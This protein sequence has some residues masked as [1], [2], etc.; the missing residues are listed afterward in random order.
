[1][2]RTNK[3][4]AKESMPWQV[5]DLTEDFTA[6]SLDFWLVKFIQEAAKQNGEPYPPR[7]FI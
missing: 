1:M 5:E 3:D 2:A 4:P 7:A 6:Q